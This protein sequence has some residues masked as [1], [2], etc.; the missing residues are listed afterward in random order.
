MSNMNNDDEFAE[1]DTTVDE[2][3]AMWDEAGQQVA[4]LWTSVV[5]S[6]PGVAAGAQRVGTSVDIESSTTRTLQPA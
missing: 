6:Q 2:F 5:M 1:L 4:Q 3:H